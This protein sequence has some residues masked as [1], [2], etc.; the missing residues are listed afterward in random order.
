MSS[1]HSPEAS[2]MRTQPSRKGKERDTMVH[3]LPIQLTITAAEKGVLLKVFTPTCHR[4]HQ[5]APN[6]SKRGHI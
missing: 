6:K 3:F 5:G 4:A 2:M 1:I